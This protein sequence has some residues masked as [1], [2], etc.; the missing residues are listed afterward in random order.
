M[1]GALIPLPGERQQVWGKPHTSSGLPQFILLEFGPPYTSLPFPV[2]GKGSKMGQ[3]RKSLPKLLI[4]P[5]S[6]AAQV[7]R[8]LEAE[9]PMGLAT[10]A[11]G[12]VLHY[13][14]P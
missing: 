4:P 11:S 14:L 10:R 7:G 6:L 3:K 1:R 8:G 2:A 9:L 5:R 13:F 12:T